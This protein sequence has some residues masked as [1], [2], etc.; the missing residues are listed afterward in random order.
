MALHNDLGKWGEDIAAEYLVAHGWYIRH[1]NRR[2]FHRELDIICID[3]D[4][5]QLIVVEVK[6]RSSTAFGNPDESIDS[7]KIHDIILATNAY[8]KL[9]RLDRLEVRYD[10]ISIIGTPQSGYTMEHKE[11]IFDVSFLA[12]YNPRRNRSKRQT[13]GRWNS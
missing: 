3:Q 5:T 8:V 2:S 7:K 12:Q 9:Y 13:F 10:S 6:T 4:A 1:R 11:G